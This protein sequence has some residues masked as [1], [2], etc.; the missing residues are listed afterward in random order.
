MNRLIALVLIM[1]GMIYINVIT[2]D[3][4]YMSGAEKHEAH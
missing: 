4:S 3:H 2:Y 1:I